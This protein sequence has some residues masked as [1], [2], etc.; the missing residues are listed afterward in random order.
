MGD[1]E[2]QRRGPAAGLMNEMDR[3]I[4]DL[5]NE[6]GKRVEVRLLR[7]PVEMVFPIGVKLLKESQARSSQLSGSSAT[8]HRVARKRW[9]RSSIC[10]SRILIL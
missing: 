10:S 8:G 4:V 3:Q 1:D 7:A 2:R 9:R 6:M 5:G